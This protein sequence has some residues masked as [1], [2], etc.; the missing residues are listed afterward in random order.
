MDSF[1]VLSII[2]EIE[3]EIGIVLQPTDVQ[4]T[5][6]QTVNNFIEFL[7]EKRK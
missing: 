2:L 4:K 7:D 6:I 5:N 1:G 3:K